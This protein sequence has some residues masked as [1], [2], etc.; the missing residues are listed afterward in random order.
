MT[1]QVGVI[2]MQ[3]ELNVVPVHA[4]YASSTFNVIEAC[5]PLMQS[6]RQLEA[7]WNAQK[8]PSFADVDYPIKLVISKIQGGEWTSSVPS[9]C[10]FDV[11]VGVYPEWQVA[12]CQ[13][14]LETTLRQ[15]AEQNP[16]LA[17]HPPTIRWHGFLSPGY[18]LPRGTDAEAALALAHEAVC[19]SPLEGHKG[20][21]L[22]DSRF[23]GLYQH[24]PAL[25]YG[26]LAKD[27]HS[28]DEAV[29]LDSLRRV[30]K[31]IARFVA[32]WCGLEAI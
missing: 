2:W 13:Q 31:V 29:N 26:P 14:E 19:Q 25:V 7:R 24:T 30:T 27:I 11:R 23:Y 6:L 16:V 10:R 8:P 20:T 4:G 32:E 22:T 18:V 28:F 15:A 17:A 3:V 5:F 9:R 1:A 12:E 21:A